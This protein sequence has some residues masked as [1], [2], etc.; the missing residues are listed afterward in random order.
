MGLLD[1]KTVLIT[2]GARG[3][4]CAHALTSAREGADVILLDITRQLDSVEYPLATADDMTETVRQVEALDRRA[5][6]FDADVRDQTQ[7]DD[8]VAA[9][10]AEFGKIDVLI[11]NAGIWTRAP[12]WEMSEQMWSDMMDV[13]LTGVWKSAKAVAPQMIER[14]SGSI[15]ITSSVNG[16]E[17]GM[18]YA[19]YVATKHGVI[20]LM[21]N[22]A[23]ELAPHG[24]RCNSINPG[25]IRTPMTDQQGAWDMFA[26][27]EGGTPD[28]LI[29]G[30]YHFHALKGHSFMPPE[31]IANTALYL[32]SD[33]AASVTGV[34]IPVDAGHLL[35]T[36]VN[37]EPVR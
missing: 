15:V 34:T 32:N 9:G 12:F 5:L 22:I 20:G 10:I 13:N 19:H 25:A 35:L 29:E 7:L 4:G 3:Q 2:G 23:L 11:A 21:K 1:G 33:L 8:A 30:G 31:V 17:P 36:G 24:I 16:L 6:T 28:D 14:Q 37:Q 27:H 26:G 18:N